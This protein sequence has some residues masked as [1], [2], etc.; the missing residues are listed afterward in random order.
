MK[1]PR[2]KNAAA[3]GAGAVSNADA[4]RDTNAAR[5]A[6]PVIKLGPQKPDRYRHPWIY[7][8][9]IA[10]V[11]EE[12]F[13]NGGLV[14]VRDGRGRI[15]GT[16]F[17]NMNSKISFR[18]LTRDPEAVVDAAF[19]L[20]RI[21]SALRFR[22]EHYAT[23]GKLPCAY[24]LA[25]GE[26]DD[27]PGFIADVYG[28]FVVVQFLALG[29]DMW[30]DAIISAIVHEL[31]PT[32]IYERSDSAVRALEGLEEQSGA[33]YG[34]EPKEIITIDDGSLKILVDL[35]SGAKTGL[36]LDQRQNQQA[37]AKQAAGRDVLNC[38]SYTGLFGLEAAKAGARSVTDV[39]ISE[40][41]NDVNK[42]QWALNGLSARHEIV[43]ANVFDHL[44][45]L[46][47]SERKYD[48]IVLD[49]PAFTK[50][51]AS[52]EGAARGYNEINR[53]AMRLL[54]PGGV[55]VTCSCSHHFSAEEF[56]D[57]VARA[58]HDARKKLR[59]IEQRG[60]PA[61]HPVLIDAPESEYLK[62]LIFEVR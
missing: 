45:I 16:G 12:G 26:A 10:S 7:D 60:Q 47:Q 44:R 40:S 23:D 3:R 33:V 19:W 39:E 20:E 22:K 25:H 11:P 32:G 38:F 34:E 31:K 59:L 14:R 57:I 50:N 21:S 41:F 2:Q 53:V 15:Q 18:Y 5:D 4:A 62:C 36:F 42:Q 61:D 13:I 58:S 30:R 17:L 24:R 1:T 43:T 6:L 35:K 49:P 52:R 55:L 48:M 37:A 28:G 51:R 56:R 9:E 46:D 29:I 27:L 54:S 8:N